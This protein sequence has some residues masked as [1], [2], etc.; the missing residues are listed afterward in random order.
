MKRIF[1]VLITLGFTTFLALAAN[2]KDQHK[3]QIWSQQKANAWYATQPWPSGCN[4]QPATAIN[5]IEMWQTE[6]FDAATIDKELGWAEG[7]GFTTMRVFLSSVVWKAE[8]IAFK[9]N[10]EKFLTIAAS[11]KIRPMFVFFDDCWKPESAI[12]RQDAPKPGVHNSGWVRDPAVSLRSDTAKLFPFLEKYVKDI[13]I[14]FKNDKRILLWDLYNEPGNSGHGITSLP[15]LRNTFKWAREVNPVQ[16]LSA[17][18]WTFGCTELNVFQIENSDVVTYHNYGNEKEHDTWINLLKIQNRPMICTEYMARRNDSKFQNI[19]PL[20]RR[21]N[22]GAIN[23]GFVSGKTNTIFAWDEP[24]PNE[25]EPV[26]WFHDI[27]RQDKT[28]FDQAEVDIIK[29]MNGK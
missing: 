7:L 6:S 27:Y 16:P 17:G 28:P 21:H 11:H 15:L 23:W 12:G 10:I 25:K 4:Y 8:P 29:K 1:I 18:V 13:M 2:Q 14:T 24:K 26:L 22:V 5:Q 19:M 20:L 3:N 9:Q